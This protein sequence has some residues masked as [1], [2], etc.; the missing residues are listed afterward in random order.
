LHKPMPIFKGE[1]Q[2]LN[3]MFLLAVTKEFVLGITVV[4]GPKSALLI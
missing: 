1:I 3:S 2:G 4:S